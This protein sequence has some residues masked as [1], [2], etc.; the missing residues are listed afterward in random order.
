MIFYRKRTVIEIKKE[1]TKEKVVHRQRDRTISKK[2]DPTI[3]KFVRRSKSA[4]GLG[5]SMGADKVSDYIE[6]GDDI[7]AV[8]DFERGVAVGTA[9]RVKK[10]K[11]VVSKIRKRPDINKVQ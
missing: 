7:K 10:T 9:S 2:G 3:K 8:M 5:A 11:G 6:G 4:L 1:E